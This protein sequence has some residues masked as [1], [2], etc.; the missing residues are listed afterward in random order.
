MCAVARKFRTNFRAARRCPLPQAV[1]RNYL[2]VSSQSPA[3][4]TVPASDTP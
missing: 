2:F 3:G 1:A 4:G